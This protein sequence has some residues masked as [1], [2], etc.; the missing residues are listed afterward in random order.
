MTNP[1]LPTPRTPGIFNSS[2]PG[3]LF[4]FFE[5]FQPQGQDNLTFHQ[6]LCK[7][8]VCYGIN[9]IPKFHQGFAFES[10]VLILKMKV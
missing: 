5:E 4:F 9:F 8:I 1:V 7:R 10:K 6:F 3:F 2:S